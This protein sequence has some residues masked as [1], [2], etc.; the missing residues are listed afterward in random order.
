MLNK[1]ATLLVLSAVGNSK[2]QMW[3]ASSGMM[4][5]PSFMKVCM[6]VHKLLMSCRHTHMY[7]CDDVVSHFS[8][9]IRK[10]G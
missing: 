9:E 1:I 8:C 7:I 4:F 10:L 3:V 2:V 5:V 6:L